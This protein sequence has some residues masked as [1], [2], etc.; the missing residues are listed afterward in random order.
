[1]PPFDSNYTIRSSKESTAV[2]SAARLAPENYTENFN[3]A[4]ELN[5]RL[6]S[7]VVTRPSYFSHSDSIFSKAWIS[8]S[9]WFWGILSQTIPYISLAEYSQKSQSLVTSTRFSFFEIEAMDESPVDR[10]A[11]LTSNLFDLS[12]FSSSTRTFS[13]NR[14]LGMHVDD[15]E[16]FLG[17]GAGI[18]QGR[19]DM[20]GGDGGERLPD[21]S[22]GFA[23][24]EHFEDLPYHDSRALERRFSVTDLRVGNNVGIDYNFRHERV[25]RAKYN[26]AYLK[27]PWLALKQV[28]RLNSGDS[29]PNSSEIRQ[30]SMLSPDSGAHRHRAVNNQPEKITAAARLATNFNEKEQEWLNELA[31]K[32]N[33]LLE[34]ALRKGGILKSQQVVFRVDSTYVDQQVREMRQAAYDETADDYLWKYTERGFVVG[35]Q[36]SSEDH[37]NYTE[38]LISPAIFEHLDNFIK[39]IADNIDALEHGGEGEPISGSAEW[40][41]L[42][43]WVSQRDFGARLAK[44]FWE[45]FISPGI[46]YSLWDGA[47][48]IRL[49]DIPTNEQNHDSSVIHLMISSLPYQKESVVRLT[50]DAPPVTLE[51]GHGAQIT[52]AFVDHAKPGYAYIHIQAVRLHYK[53][54]QVFAKEF[55]LKASGEMLPYD[56]FKAV[57]EII[58]NELPV[59]MSTLS[60]IARFRKWM[61]LS[62]A[63]DRPLIIWQNMRLG[64]LYPYFTEFLRKQMGVVEIMSDE[65]EKIT[66]GEGVTPEISSARYLLVKH[67]YPSSGVGFFRQK[68][69]LTN[70]GKFAQTLKAPVVMV[71]SSRAL[72]SQ[73]MKDV[74]D[75]HLTKLVPDWEAV[76]EDNGW[77]EMDFTS[78]QKKLARPAFLILVNRTPIYHISWMDG[79]IFMEEAEG[80]NLVEWPDEKYVFIDDEIHEVSQLSREVY[81]DAIDEYVHAHPEILNGA[82]LAKEPDPSASLNS[83]HSIPNSP[84]S[85]QLSKL[86][87]DSGV[88]PRLESGES[89]PL[90]APGGAKVYLD[91][92]LAELSGW[93]ESLDPEQQRMASHIK[94]NIAILSAVLDGFYQSDGD[95]LRHNFSN[96]YQDLKRYKQ[97]LVSGLKLPRNEFITVNLLLAKTSSLLFALRSGVQEQPLLRQKIADLLGVLGTIQPKDDANGLDEQFQNAKQIILEIVDEDRFHSLSKSH[98]G[99]GPES[100]L[101]DMSL[102]RV[103]ATNK[104]APILDKK[105]GVFR[106]SAQAMAVSPDGRRIAIGYFFG[107]VDI[108]AM[109]RGN[110]VASFPPVDAKPDSGNRYSVIKIAFVDNNRVRWIERGG[111]IMEVDSDNGEIRN[112][113]NSPSQGLDIHTAAFS[114]DAE[115]LV[116]ADRWGSFNARMFL[117]DFKTKQWKKISDFPELPRA[118]AVNSKFLAMAFNNHF[119]LQDFLASEKQKKIEFG[120]SINYVESMSFNE[121]EKLLLFVHGLHKISSLDIET[122]Q[123]KF[124][125][126]FSKPDNTG[127]SYFYMDTPRAQ[128]LTNSDAG[129]QIV[130]SHDPV[131]RSLILDGSGNDQNVIDTTTTRHLP[132]PSADAA[133]LADTLDINPRFDMNTGRQMPFRPLWARFL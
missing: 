35:R 79:S 57:D 87:P 22:D 94:T 91:R 33:N 118:V 61:D 88:R 15:S 114:S 28:Q 63:S 74:T 128:I 36:E 113:G 89:D 21:A 71:D 25:S 132:G 51:L 112:V 32:I 29:I 20:F 4:G 38:Y 82:R 31:N 100:I 103:W 7:R 122:G 67:K 62:G 5:Q 37:A 50:Q 12:N 90:H 86:L 23:R 126:Y 46:P 110:L 14:N 43:A 52:L 131:F 95:L 41:T 133:R 80:R 64:G 30:L 68:F 66:K 119:I 49:P 84:Q 73:A 1:M 101:S 48:K 121:N 3:T 60:D 93:H 8:T 107:T 120:E 97:S 77:A 111:R 115:S 76:S 116:I 109:D 127:D 16:A 70:L 39:L 45:V 96:L 117:F 65:L 42:K 19:F 72:H 53:K 34:E 55:K 24:R 44:P 54:K 98:I 75:H 85:R 105:I 104:F 99:P 83:S 17:D 108:L 6:G 130:F 47:V 10:E 13:S 40:S 102:S 92:F 78:F 18:F 9:G 58:K 124:L 59:A 81:G 11:S 26:T 69:F 129:Q 125:G 2:L 123:I 27:Y 106:Q 56:G